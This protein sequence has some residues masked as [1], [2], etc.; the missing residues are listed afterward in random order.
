[1]SIDLGTSAGGL[2]F[3]VWEGGEGYADERTGGIHVQRGAEFI[4]SASRVED[5]GEVVTFQLDDFMPGDSFRVSL[6]VDDPDDGG[7]PGPDDDASARDMAGTKLAARMF[8]AAGFERAEITEFGEV[9]NARLAW[10]RA[11]VTGETSPIDPYPEGA[12]GAD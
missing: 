1:V 5:G 11:C 3:D 4:N 7:V 8:N 10:K 9:G 12:P 2:V 6:D